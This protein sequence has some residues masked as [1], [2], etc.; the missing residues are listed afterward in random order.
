MT[1]SGR[2]QANTPAPGA[3]QTLIERGLSRLRSASP[4]AAA[5]LDDAAFA[6]RVS[7]VIVASDFALETLRRQPALLTT[8]AD[9]DGAASIAAPVLLAGQAPHWPEQLRLYRAAA[10][11]R[12]SAQAAIFAKARADL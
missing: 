12:R 2:M 5:L 7:R 9:D 8:F 6:A 10:S 1:Q 3:L 11:T 4:E